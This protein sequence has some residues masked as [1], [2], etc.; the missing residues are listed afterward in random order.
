MDILEMNCCEVE[1]EMHLLSTD[2]NFK[3]TIVEL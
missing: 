2:D 1:W 3:Q